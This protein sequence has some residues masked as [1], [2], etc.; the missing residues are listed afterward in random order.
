MIACRKYRV[1]LW[2]LLWLV[3][4]DSRAH[5]CVGARPLGMGGAFIAVADDMTAAYWNPAGLAELGKQ[6][7]HSTIT[8]TPPGDEMGY[9]SFYVAGYAVGKYDAGMAFS[10][11]ERL[12]LSGVLERWY[13]GSLAARVSSMSPISVGVNL[14][15]EDHSDGNERTQADLGLLWALDKRWNLGVLWQSLGNFRPGAS[16]KLSENT[17]VAVD[18]YNALKNPNIL[19]GQ[20]RVMWGVE[21][22]HKPLSY[23]LGA[24]AGDP[25]MGIGYSG[26]NVDIDIA[27]V[28]RSDTILLFGVSLKRNSRALG[29]RAGA[30]CGRDPTRARAG[31]GAETRASCVQGDPLTPGSTCVGV[32]AVVR[33]TPDGRKQR[34]RSL[35]GPGTCCTG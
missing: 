6:G 2:I 25:T 13:V 1:V 27:A 26:E 33:I 15:Y 19:D 21:V 12:R 30:A 22:D 18:I 4:W 32:A 23:R 10:Y 28:F 9:R 17:I 24:Y 29:R 16:L 8:L 11:V 20:S 14:R 31:E 3:C 35:Q 5:A 7:V 34:A